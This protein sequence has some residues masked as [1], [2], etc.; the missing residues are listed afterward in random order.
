MDTM[1]VKVET[2]AG[3]RSAVL[4]A[5]K[6]QGNS[7]ADT[8]QRWLAKMEWELQEKD[9]EIALLRRATREDLDVVQVQ[10]GEQSI[11]MHQKHQSIAEATFLEEEERR[12]KR[13]IAIEEWSVNVKARI[14]QESA[15]IAM[16]R[17]R[18][19]LADHLIEIKESNG[20]LRAF[21]A[22]MEE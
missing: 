22:R 4:R 13:Q 12:V 17:E 5:S 20:T 15:D 7:K 19:A 11:L 21:A 2:M 16:R 14:D 18:R 1:S 3:N 8:L 10:Q 9:E 6:Q